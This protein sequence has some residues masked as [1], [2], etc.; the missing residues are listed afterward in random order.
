MRK[1]IRPKHRAKVQAD[2]HAIPLQIDSLDDCFGVFYR[3]DL[4][5]RFDLLSIA[6]TACF[7]S[8]AERPRF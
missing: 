4:S 3:P 8:A 5:A 7:N 1:L 6:S 2:L